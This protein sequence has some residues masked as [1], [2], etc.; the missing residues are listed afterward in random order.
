MKPSLGEIQTSGPALGL[1]EVASIADGFAVADRVVKEAAVDL[2]VARPV[3]PGKF[4]VLFA[5]SVPEVASAS[6]AGQHGL[7]SKAL[8]E[9]FLPHVD[10]QVLEA[11]RG[12][13]TCT[14]QALGVVETDTAATAVVAADLA[15]KTAAV[16]VLRLRL[17]VGMG[18]KA[19][20]TLS[21]EVSQV[22]AA[23]HAAAGFAEEYGHLLQQVVIPQPHTDLEPF[24]Q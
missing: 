5:G 6:R 22:R 13:R 20:F 14:L 2:L 1:L 16:E 4:L 21:G 24:L 10:G 15:V 8:D 19:F 7:S 18:G 11:L 17:A 3:S 12:T 23:V 9:L